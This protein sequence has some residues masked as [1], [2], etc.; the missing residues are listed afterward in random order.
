V[1]H[2]EIPP[3]LRQAERLRIGQQCV[4]N[5]G[6]QDNQIADQDRGSQCCAMLHDTGY[7]AAMIT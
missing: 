4:V 3:A 7:L 1:I 5:L 2:Y 6:A